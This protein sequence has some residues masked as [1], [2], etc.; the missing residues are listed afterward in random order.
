VTKERAEDFTA[1]K[2]QVKVF[3]IVKP[4]SVAVGYQ[5]HAPSQPRRPQ[6]ETHAFFIP[7]SL[8]LSLCVNATAVVPN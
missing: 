6:L 4:C 3:W 5:R 8:L 1:V 2:I 7:H